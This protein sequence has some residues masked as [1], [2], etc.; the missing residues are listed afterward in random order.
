MKPRRIQALVI[1]AAVVG[2][3]ACDEKLRDIAGPTP[4]LTPTLASVQRFVFSAPDSSGRLACTGCHTNVGRTPS[5]GLNLIEGSSY[6]AL[7]GV[8]STQKPGAIRVIAGDPGNSYLLKKLDG[9]SD[10]AGVRMPRGNGPFLTPGQ[11]SILRRWI[12]LGAK[13]N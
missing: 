4:Q 10:I 9:S 2:V 7:V 3:A 11:I 12:E 8:P 6:Q 13:N 1:A 5:G